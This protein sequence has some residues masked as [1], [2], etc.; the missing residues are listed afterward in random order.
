MTL[1]PVGNISL[2]LQVVILFLLVLGLPF[3][4][5]QTGKKEQKNLIAHGY[6]TVA[7]LVMHTIL[8]L[9]IMIPSLVY[10]LPEISDLSAF[11]AFM[12]FSHAILGTLAWILGLVII[13]FW[14]GKGPKKMTCWKYRKWMAPIF[15]I[16]AISIVNGAVVH[17]L[18]MI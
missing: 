5:G 3:F 6:S 12:V 9:L 18:S 2:V 14:L 1:D 4:R 17:I 7:A 8:I 16:W 13:T 15:V 11:D 10:G